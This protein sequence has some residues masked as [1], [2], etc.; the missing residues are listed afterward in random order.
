VYRLKFARVST[1]RL[2]RAAATLGAQTPYEAQQL[3]QQLGDL[4]GGGGSGGGG[5]RPTGVSSSAKEVGIDKVVRE[6]LTP[7][8]KMMVDE[9]TNSLIVTDLGENFPR[10]EAVLNALDIK[11]MQVLIEAEVLET[12]LAKLKD[13]GVEWGSGTEGS[14]LAVNG[15]TRTT[16]APFSTFFGDKTGG[17]TSVTMG[18]ID[19]SLLDPT[20]Q[21]L[22]R[23]TETKILARPKVLTLEN[24]SAVIRLTSPQAVA[25]SSV[26]VSESGDLLQTPERMTTGIIL[27]VTPEINENGYITMLVEP[28]VTK[29]VTSEISSSIVDPKTRS[30]RALVRVR[31]GHTLVLGGLIDRTERDIVQRV[32]VLSGI[33]F[34]GGAFKNTERN[35]SA[36]ELVVFVTPRIMSEPTGTRVA[37]QGSASSTA[38]EQE[39]VP[40]RQ[41]LIEETLTRLNKM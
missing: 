15:A 6:L 20:I 12:T 9:R 26:T 24:E 10:I 29:T 14:M 38:R 28:S 18:T 11:T 21:A 35:D 30:A 5:S 37:W 36:S 33:P 19:A 2:A 22:E 23:D 31:N 34:I 8:G 27:V 17:A 40:S 3:T 13:L 7:Q 32:P 25:I 39:G 16:R 4:T 1:S 41:Q